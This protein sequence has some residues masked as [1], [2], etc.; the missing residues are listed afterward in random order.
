[1]RRILALPLMLTACMPAGSSAPAPANALVCAEQLAMGIGY[2]VVARTEES[3]RGTFMAERVVP[4]DDVEP[5]LAVVTASLFRR[6]SDVRLSVSGS[7]FR[8]RPGPLPTVLNPGTPER[9]VQIGTI[10]TRRGM[11]R[12]SAGSVA[13]DARMILQQCSGAGEATPAARMAQSR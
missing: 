4:G 11:Q 10:R 8:A 9:G 7:R 5:A 12:L 2:T 3:G 1:M 13:E 6:G